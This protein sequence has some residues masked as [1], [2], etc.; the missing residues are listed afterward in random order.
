MMLKNGV[1]FTTNALGPP[2]GGLELL[3]SVGAIVMHA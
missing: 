1:S 3:K 2:P